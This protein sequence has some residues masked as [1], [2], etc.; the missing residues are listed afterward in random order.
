MKKYEAR[1]VFELGLQVLLLEERSALRLH[2][3]ALRRQRRNRRLA[4]A[5]RRLDVAAPGERRR[6]LLLQRVDVRLGDALQIHRTY[7]NAVPV[8]VAM[9]AVV[10]RSHAAC[11]CRYA[12]PQH[13]TCAA[14]T[15]RSGCL[16]GTANTEVG[17]FPMRRNHW[18]HLL[19]FSRLDRAL[20]LRDV[21]IQLRALRRQRVRRRLL[22]RRR[23]VELRELPRQ[24]G[25]A[26]AKVFHLPRLAAAR[27]GVARSLR[28][29]RCA[30]RLHL[31]TLTRT[32][33][34]P[35]A[36]QAR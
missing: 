10:P 12:V 30:L 20:E 27:A 21:K 22:A 13:C 5:A 28:L 23:L 24:V 14:E 19:R 18:P 2:R 11:C 15:R 17:S 6:Q 34:P 36:A 26:L 33:L 9:V 32:F 7:I 4:R 8:V 16:R 1:L 31:R 35:F 29:Q 25:R 3:A